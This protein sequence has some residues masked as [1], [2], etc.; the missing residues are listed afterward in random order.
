MSVSSWAVIIIAEEGGGKEDTM[1]PVIAILGLMF[2]TWVVA[3]YAT[4]VD[5]PRQETTL[6]KESS[7]K[8]V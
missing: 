7:R 5:E 3:M 1:I 8:A 6:I 4:Y 2:F